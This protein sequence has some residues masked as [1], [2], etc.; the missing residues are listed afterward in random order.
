VEK[1]G[2][3]TPLLDVCHQPQELQVWNR[4]HLPRSF[5]PDAAL[6]NP[7]KC[8]EKRMDMESELKLF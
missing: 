8:F 3:R 1:A 7:R 4:E 5:E 6:V 2:L